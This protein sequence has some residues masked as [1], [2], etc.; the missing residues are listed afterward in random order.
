MSPCCPGSWLSGAS[1]SHSHVTFIKDTGVVAAVGSHTARTHMC[2]S[3]HHLSHWSDGELTTKGLSAHHWTMG[4]A[5]NPR[6][7]HMYSCA[8]TLSGV[9]VILE[10]HPCGTVIQLGE[11]L[12]VCHMHKRKCALHVGVLCPGRRARVHECVHACVHV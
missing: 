6:V 8:H 9:P 11:R 2:D 5:S 3:S 12:C 10:A 4:S 1:S 7:P